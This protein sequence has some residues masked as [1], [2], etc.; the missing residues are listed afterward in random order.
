MSIEDSGSVVIQGESEDEYLDIDF[1]NEKPKNYLSREWCHLI[2]KVGQKFLG[3]A[4][5]FRLKL[6]KYAIETG[7]LFDFKRNDSRCIE[8]VCKKRDDHQC[9]WHIKCSKST[10]TNIWYILKMD[11]V[12]TCPGMLRG[13]KSKLLTAAVVKS[14]IINEIRMNPGMKA[15]EIMKKF[16]LG[17]EFEIPYKTAYRGKEKAVKSINGGA[18]DSYNMLVWY[19]HAVLEADPN[20]VFVLECDPTSN[21]FKRLFVAYGGCIRGFQYCVPMLFVDGTFGKSIYKGQLL[22]ATGKNG[23][24]GMLPV[25]GSIIL[26][27]SAVITSC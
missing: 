4:M 15:K 9:M 16:Y 22:C 21:R 20:S 19:Q 2:E 13:T 5:E 6:S 1:K 12:H 17:Y 14:E 23:N 25:C 18:A 11:N 24:G 8:A 3:G 10:Y 7:F 27:N 26:Y